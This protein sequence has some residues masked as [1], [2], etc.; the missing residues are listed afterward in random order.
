MVSNCQLS[1]AYLSTSTNFIV[2]AI[3]V[4][5]SVIFLESTYVK[6]NTEYLT[7]G[8]LSYNS[9][10][11]TSNSV[12]TIH[13]VGGMLCHTINHNKISLHKTKFTENTGCGVLIK[14]T[15]SVLIQDNLIEKNHGIGVNVIDSSN[16]SLIGNKIIENLH[17]GALLVNCNGL[18]ILNSFFKNKHN[19]LKIE[20]LQNQ[21]IT[22]KIMKNTVCENYLNGIAVKGVHN[23]PI[24]M[25]NERIA[26]NNLA[27]IHVSEKA[28]PTIKDNKVFENMNQGVLLVTDS[29]ACI[30]NNEVF[31]NIKANIAFGGLLAEKTKI[32]S[33]KIWGSRNEGIFLIKGAGGLISKNEI[34]DNNDG[35]I[36]VNSKP[37]ISYNNIYNNIRTGVLI[38]DKSDVKLIGNTIHDNQFLGLFIRDKSEGEISNNDMNLNISQLYLST[39][40]SQLLK[41]IKER[42][43][44]T[45]RVDVASNCNIL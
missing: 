22:C 31:K 32:I 41:G 27:G 24:I 13:R 21:E 40:C 8:L 43:N 16:L 2:P 36:V 26:Y 38:S 39:D 19:G 7:I 15:G 37:D 6:G 28:N 45:G 3:Y 30:E 29:S 14:G 17:D 42:N 34:Y 11:K 4:E 23:N 5:N 20:T 18:I 12:F 35:V 10:I 44:I 9:N 25:N 33:N 1:L